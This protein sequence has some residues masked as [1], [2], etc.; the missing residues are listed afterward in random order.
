MRLHWYGRNACNRPLHRPLQIPYWDQQKYCRI[1][2]AICQSNGQKMK[3]MLRHNNKIGVNLCARLLYIHKRVRPT[4]LLNAKYYLFPSR[5]YFYIE[6]VVI[7]LY[8][9]ILLSF[10]LQPIKF[11]LMN[12]EIKKMISYYSGCK[13]PKY[14]DASIEQAI[15]K[16]RHFFNDS[17]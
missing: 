8:W 15:R 14:V 4:S 5:F 1:Y 2:E 12:D 13:W 16:R 9:N 10:L 7:L 17:K 3:N 11:L 6:A